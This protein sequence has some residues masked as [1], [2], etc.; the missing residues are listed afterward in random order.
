[1]ASDAEQES[2]EEEEEPEE[3][4]AE[5][6]DDDAVAFAFRN[7]RV[8]FKGTYPIDRPVTSRFHPATGPL[9]RHQLALNLK[10][11]RTYPIEEPVLPPLKVV[12]VGSGPV[13]LH[14]RRFYVVF[15]FPHPQ[16]GFH[17]VFCTAKQKSVLTQFLSSQSET[18]MKG[19]DK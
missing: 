12:Q 3:E 2:E 11:A 9:R 10:N 5:Q 7:K 4:E 18:D 19:K 16:F 1:M 8:V 14:E 6:G 15:V 17:L 13:V